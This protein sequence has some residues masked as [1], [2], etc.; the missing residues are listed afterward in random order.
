M[1]GLI[2]VLIFILALGCFALIPLFIASY[3]KLSTF[4][5]LFSSVVGVF[6]LLT[7]LNKRGRMGRGAPQ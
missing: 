6:F 4:W 1:Q 5:S 7:T 3:Y 2:K